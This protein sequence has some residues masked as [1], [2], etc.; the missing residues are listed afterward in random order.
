[1]I[2]GDGWYRGSINASSSRNAHGTQ[3]ALL[4]QLK[5]TYADGSHEWICSDESW[6]TS[7]G[8]ILKSDF[9]DGEIYDAR[10]ELVGWNELGFNDR[11]WQGV[12]IAGF[13]YQ[14]LISS[15]GSPVRKMETFPPVKIITTPKG[16]TVLDFGQNFA[17]YAVMRVQGN[18]GTTV[19]LQYSE[20]LDE[21]G[22]F[23]LSYLGS[24]GGVIPPLLQ[25]DEYTLNGKG[26]EVY[27][28]HFTVRGFRYL[29]IDG[30]PGEVKAENFTAYAVYSDMGETGKFECSNP[31]LNQ[32]HQ[33]VLWSQKGNFLDIP[34]DCPTRERAGW[35]GDAQI[36]VHAGSLLMNDAAFYAKWIKDVSAE[37]YKNGVIRNFVPAAPPEKTNRLMNAIEGSSGWGDAIVIIPWTLYQMFGDRTV[38]EDEYE[39]MKKWVEYERRRAEKTHW[40][41]K[42][43]PAYWLDADRRARQKYIWDT[44]YHW[45]EWLEPDIPLKDALKY[46][47]K[48]MFFGDPIVASAYFAYSCRLMAKVAKVLGKVQEAEEYEALAEKCKEAYI[49]E[50]IRADGSMTMY[51]EKQAPYVRALAMGLYNRELHPKLLQKLI[52]RVEKS[53]RHLGTGFLSTPFL[54]NVLSENGRSDLA[55]AILLQEDNPSWLYAIDHGAT[56]I[57]EDWKGIDEK[58]VPRAS[59]NHYSK[60]AVISWI[61][62]TTCGIQLDPEV[63]AYK[64]FFLKPQPGGGLTYATASYES[65][66]GEIK[67]GWE[68]TG[69]GTKYTFTVP[70]NTHA[71]VTLEHVKTFPQA[72]EV[73]NFRQ[74][75]NS[76]EFELL[77]G[78]YEFVVME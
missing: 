2:L 66:Y 1:V 46:I 37:Q 64:H 73:E 24:G 7:T 25:R 3:L 59:L 72:V 51:T 4:S 14:N 49:K 33:N 26:V 18:A 41:K 58:G 8:P 5:I 42:L 60:G 38:L 28:P 12:Y 15:E 62:E 52:E 61:Y 69:Q 10:L 13:G 31:K 45:G 53:N 19:K 40:S 32:L 50:F 17:G 78:S 9:K 44:N 16:E 71:T 36:F 56:T 57:W 20:T 55:Y 48:N 67:S 39:S 75:E 30:Y 54:C 29:W 23:T 34:T 74:L 63:P 43:Q 76:V 35:T 22:N 77:S 6:K 65:L 70:A 11:N 27:E 21:N 47:L 68:K